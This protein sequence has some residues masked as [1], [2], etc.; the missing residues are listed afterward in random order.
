MCVGLEGRPQLG[1]DSLAATHWRVEYVP[2]KQSRDDNVESFTDDDIE[3]YDDGYWL[4]NKGHGEA[5]PGR[6]GFS[7]HRNTTDVKSTATGNNVRH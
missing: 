3:A 5:S 4:G 6:A 7:V 2:T 1:S